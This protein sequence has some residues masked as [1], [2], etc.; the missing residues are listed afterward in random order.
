MLYL[1]RRPHT[2]VVKVSVT[3][4]VLYDQLASSAIKLF[5]MKRGRAERQ[6]H[7]EPVDSSE[8]RSA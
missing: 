2:A 3:N 4:F 1:N 7:C 5:F 6:M 8:T